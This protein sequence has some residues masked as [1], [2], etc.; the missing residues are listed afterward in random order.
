MVTRSFEI[1]TQSTQVLVTLSRWPCDLLDLEPNRKHGEGK[2]EGK[3]LLVSL[4]GQQEVEV[5]VLMKGVQYSR[6]ITLKEEPK[7]SIGKSTIGNINCW[8]T[9]VL[10]LPCL[11]HIWCL[12][13]RGLCA[14][15]ASSYQRC[16]NQCNSKLELCQ[17]GS[18]FHYQ[19][20]F[21]KKSHFRVPQCMNTNHICCHGKCPV[22]NSTVH[23]LWRK[24]GQPERTTQETNPRR[25]PKFVT[26]KIPT[27]LQ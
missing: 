12:D 2:G 20:C 27:P 15:P 4:Y 14:F 10:D 17:E 16:T 21:P 23:Y 6:K 19:L 7:K 26:T 18:L 1:A 24:A 5:L 8:D 9:P 25:K 13:G 22:L 11:A 3:L